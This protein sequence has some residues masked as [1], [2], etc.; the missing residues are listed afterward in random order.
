MLD[1]TLCD[2]A[3]I[4]RDPSFDGRFFYR[5]PPSEIRRQR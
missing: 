2:G 5:R 4:A 1:F 3:R